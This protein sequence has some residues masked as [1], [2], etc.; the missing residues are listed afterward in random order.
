MK[1]I[2]FHEHGGPEVLSYG[3][4]E[5]PQPGYGEAQVQIK[6]AALNRLDIFVRNGWPGI[7]LTY[8]HI[9]GADGAGVVSAVGEGVT[10]F[11]V[12][13]RVVINGT[14]SCGE[15][16]YCLAGQDNYCRKGSVLGEHRHGTFAEYIT[17]PTRSLTHLPD[18]LPFEDA[19]AASLVYMTAWHSLITR[20]NLRPGESVLIIG[21]GGGVNTA[22]IQIAKLAGAIVYVVGSTEE[23]LAKAGELGADFL[24]NR[25][26]EEDWGRAVYKLTGKRGV[27][28]V[29][30]NVG[31]A[32]WSA[33]LRALRPGGRMLVVGGSS[34]YKAQAGVNYIFA[35][36]LSIIGSTMAPQADFHTVMEL[37]FASKLKA[38][39]DR[40]MPLA[41]GAQAFEQME[42]GDVIGKLVL[43]P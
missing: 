18:T 34:G 40:V 17:L 2:Y 32:T 4:V 43:K 8:P 9:P 31:Q 3:D 29:V 41:D 27:D 10:G 39:I 20:G 35:R 30:D 23:K 6:A 12:G 7:K 25:S 22:S 15:C 16:E 5:T 1:A 38:V 28:V 24:V 13:D 36:H 42:R 37:L 14:I 21:A 19:A 11:T 33:S 26:E